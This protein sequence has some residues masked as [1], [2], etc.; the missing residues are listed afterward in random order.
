MAYKLGDG[1]WIPIDLSK[2]AIGSENVA[3]DGKPDLRF[4][5]WFRVGSVQ[6]NKG[7]NTIRFR[8][9]SK[10]SNHGYLDCFV[11]SDEHFQPRGILKPEQ[12]AGADKQIAEENQ[13]WFVFKPRIELPEGPKRA[14]VQEE[15]NLRWLNEK[16][17]GEGG[18]VRVKG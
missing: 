9:D 1:Q 18:V 10:N 14:D 13:G 15:L 6:L 12:I 17:A 4:I 8:M 7:K 11:L 2:G 16:F 5:A 3:A